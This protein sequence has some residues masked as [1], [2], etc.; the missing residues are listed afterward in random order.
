MSYKDFSEKYNITLNEQ[1]KKAATTINGAVLLLAVPGSGKTTTLITRLGYMI[2]ECNINPSEILTLT[3]TVAATND[4]KDRYAQMFGKDAAD[5]V[6]FRTI[7]GICAKII[8]Y[9]GQVINKTPFQLVQ[10]EKN[11]NKFLTKIW[12]KYNREY[13]TES[14][15][16]NIRTAITYIKNMLMNDDEIKALSTWPYPDIPLIEIY[17]GYCKAMRENKLIDYDDQL[18]Y[19]YKILNLYPNILKHFSDIYKYICVD[20]AQDTSK[21]Q[22][23]I[24]QMLANAGNNNIFMVGDEDQSIYGFRAAY[25]QALLDFEKIYND[26][27]ILLM[28]K[29]YRSNNEIVNVAD[30]FIQKNKFRHPKN[31]IS[32]HSEDGSVSILKYKSRNEQYNKLEKILCSQSHNN[33]AILYRENDS[34]IPIIDILDKNNIAFSLKGG[35]F[36]FFSNRLVIDIINIIKFAY[37]PQNTE[38]FMQIYFKLGL[39]INRNQ[40]LQMCEYSK[41]KN[42][43]ILLSA[44]RMNIGYE[45]IFNSSQI[46]KIHDAYQSFLM[47][48][49]KNIYAKQV[50]SY[51]YYEMNYEEYAIKC[52]LDRNKY[53]ILNIIASS[54]QMQSARALIERISYIYNLI[55]ISSNKFSGIILSTIHSSK[56]L[57]YDD[58]YI[59]DVSDG[60]YPRNVT[61]YSS[62]MSEN[63][64]KEYETYEEERRMYYVAMT[65]ARKNLCICTYLFS[66]LIRLMDIN[67]DNTKQTSQNDVS[68]LS[69][70]FNISKNI[71]INNDMSIYDIY[72]KCIESKE[73][74]RGKHHIFGIFTVK[75]LNRDG[76]LTILLNDNTVKKLSLKAFSEIIVEN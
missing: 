25:P 65:R 75:E 14:D 53:D 7:N 51:I 13:P 36:T 76:V 47:I 41:N 62:Y 2:E 20:E 35:D 27:I 68:S 32:T 23:K 64:K 58:V 56:G 19:A 15:I 61:E 1:Q 45:P 29:N 17:N 70:V 24:I 67:I 8:M 4:M 59:I 63:T 52:N 22:H 6:E 33:T 46:E 30:A 54:L 42:I 74:L 11:T 57:E 48:S 21:I 10:D 60:V 44:A 26:A 16:K 49:K 28:E 72:M 39:F 71:P 43:P 34:C 40:A 38:L 9:Y 37:E 18:V 3:Y 66:S 31:I 69:I 73:K 55:K 12:T 50:V 5:K